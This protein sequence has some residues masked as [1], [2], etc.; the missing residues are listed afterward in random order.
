MTSTI[1]DVLWICAGIAAIGGIDYCVV[2]FNAYRAS[3][4]PA[5][6]GASPV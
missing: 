4:K 3:K 5:P 1:Q 6:R 2:K